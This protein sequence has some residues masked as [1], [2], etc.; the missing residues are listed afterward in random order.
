MKSPPRKP[1]WTLNRDKFVVRS[2]HTEGAIFFAR[3]GSSK[4]PPISN[5][6][7]YP[8]LLRFQLIMEKGVDVLCLLPVIFLWFVITVHCVCMC[9]CVFIK[10]HITVC[11]CVYLLNCT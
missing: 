4:G 10:L 5:D 7:S 2:P 1:P 3:G 9:V 11:V 8:V 6:P